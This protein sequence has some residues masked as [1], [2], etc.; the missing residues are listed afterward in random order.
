MREIVRKYSLSSFY[1]ITFILSFILLIVHFVFQSAGKYSIS[2]TQLAPALSV[3]VIGFILKDANLFKDILSHFSSDKFQIKWLIIAISIPTICI[4]ISG[5]ILEYYQI[6]FVLWNGDMLFYGI[7][8]FAIFIGCVAEEIGWRGYV[9][10]ELQ[11]RVTPFY[12]SLIVGI[13]WGIWHLNFTGGLL[14]FSLYTF[15]IIEMSICM[16]WLYNKTN[17][18][19]WFMSVWHISFNLASHIFLWE[20]FNI[21]LFIVESI[22][23]GILSIFLLIY[24]RETFFQKLKVEGNTL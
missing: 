23:F 8:I 24:D 22:V 17:G 19:L 4:V 21:T 12:S 16:T 9:L 11:K 14:G 13:L 15:T 18:N 1:V 3:V 20:R 7:N 6:H 2:F 10:P 5:Y